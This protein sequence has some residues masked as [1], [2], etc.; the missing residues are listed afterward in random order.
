VASSIDIGCGGGGE[1]LQIFSTVVSSDTFTMLLAEF[2]CL[3][4][5]GILDG[6][7]LWLKGQ[8]IYISVVS[9]DT[10]TMLLAE[11]RSLNI[12]DILV[13]YDVVKRSA[14]LG[15]GCQI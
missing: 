4:H 12:L 9:S 15:E 11:V 10:F 1:S 8:Q 7:L 3:F 6:L 14:D 5:S 2:C 13:A